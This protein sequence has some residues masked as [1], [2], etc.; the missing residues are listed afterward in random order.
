MIQAFL[1]AKHWQLFILIFGLPLIF[2]IVMMTA[3]FSNLDS[4][5]NPDP[6]FM[7]SYMKYFPLVMVIYVGIFFGWFWSVGMGLQNKIPENIKMKV[8]NFKIFFFIPL[9]YIF[10]ILAF[11][12]IIMGKMMSSDGVQ[13]ISLMIGVFAIIVPLHLFSVFCMFYILYFVAKTIKTVEL[14][15][16]V[17][18]GDFA[19]EF[20]LIWF[21]PIGVWFIQPRINR[22]IGIDANPGLEKREGYLKR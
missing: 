16:E 9:I 12:R 4:T 17:K 10:L 6:T 3:M 1:K 11:S 8:K 2:Q 18:F 14:Q 19:A 13:D 15:R 7:F 20:F 5:Y 21:Y 22:M